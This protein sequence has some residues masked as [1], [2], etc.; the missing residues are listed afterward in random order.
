MVALME[1]MKVVEMVQTTVV[2][3]AGQ[4]DVSTVEMLVQYLDYA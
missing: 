4:L 3:M 1:C 2:L